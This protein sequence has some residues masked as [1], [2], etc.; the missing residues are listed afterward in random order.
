MDPPDA[1]MLA[2]FKVSVSQ[3]AIVPFVTAT[4]SP[5]FLVT[6]R[7]FDLIRAILCGL[8]DRPLMVLTGQRR[9]SSCETNGE[10]WRIGMIPASVLC[11]K[12][13]LEC[14]S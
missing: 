3:V 7:L 8:Q 2:S 6:K 13:W 10:G 14:Y 9:L 5:C 12:R 1:L 4:P 11:S